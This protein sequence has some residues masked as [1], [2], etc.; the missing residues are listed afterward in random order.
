[1][2]PLLGADGL[3]KPALDFFL[4]KLVL[5]WLPEWLITETPAL[6]FLV[7]MLPVIAAEATPWFAL[8]AVL[9]FWD[10]C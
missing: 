3:L 10:V 4:L 7:P 5:M 6:L 8:I 2:P 1:V 9:N